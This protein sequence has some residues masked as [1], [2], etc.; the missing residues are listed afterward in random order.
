MKKFFAQF[1][2]L[3]AL[4]TYTQDANASA[5]ATAEGEAAVARARLTGPPLFEVTIDGIEKFTAF[6]SCHDL[7]LNKLPKPLPDLFLGFDNLIQEAVIQLLTKARLEK[8]GLISNKPLTWLQEIEEPCKS[9]IIRI[10]NI[11]IHAHKL[12][13]EITVNDFTEFGVDEIINEYEYWKGMDYTLVDFYS[14][15]GAVEG[16]ETNEEALEAEKTAGTSSCKKDTK[17]LI[18]DIKSSIHQMLNPM[19]ELD[20]HQENYLKGMIEIDD[21]ESVYIRNRM[22]LP[23]LIDLVKKL[24]GSKLVVVGQAHFVGKEGLLNLLKITHNARIQRLNYKTNK[25]EEFDMREYLK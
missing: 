14:K 17:T 1:T 10:L 24:K 12:D 25:F 7:E 16:L 18:E 9:E 4:F 21:D 20:E 3:I 22:W 11:V 19:P 8:S 2:L 5:A 6:G 23:R 13:Q 15:K